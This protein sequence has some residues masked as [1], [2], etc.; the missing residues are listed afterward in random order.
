MWDTYKY[1]PYKLSYGK[2]DSLN[3]STN[4]YF[5]AFWLPESDKSILP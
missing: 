2:I 3:M 4:V 1:L 5:F